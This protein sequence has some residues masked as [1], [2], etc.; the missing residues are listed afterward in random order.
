MLAKENVIA[1]KKVTFVAQFNITV[2]MH[3]RTRPVSLY[4]GVVVKKCQ[5]YLFNSVKIHCTCHQL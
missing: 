2:H 3:K 1:R 4:C 5:G